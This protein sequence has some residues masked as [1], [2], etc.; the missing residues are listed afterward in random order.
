MQ[1]KREDRQLI[2]RPMTET[3]LYSKIGYRIVIDGNGVCVLP[4][5]S[6]L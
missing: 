4:A 2:L 6:L 5:V 1:C 3:A